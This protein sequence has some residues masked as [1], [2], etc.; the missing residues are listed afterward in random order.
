MI[1]LEAHSRFSLM[2]GTPGVRQLVARAVEHGMRALAL[3]DTGGLYGAVPFYQAAREAGVS[4]I[5]GARLGPCVVLARDRDGYGQL[6]FLV[7]VLQ[8]GEKGHAEQTGRMGNV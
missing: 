8:L 3:A 6:C 2:E 5:L 1:H 7:T 4:P